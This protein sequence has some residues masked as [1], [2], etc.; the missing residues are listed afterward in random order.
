M[1]IYSRLY[2]TI[3]TEINAKSDE[4]IMKLTKG[5]LEVAEYECEMEVTQEVVNH[6]TKEK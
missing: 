5:E 2:Q 3:A 6:K 4:V 1:C